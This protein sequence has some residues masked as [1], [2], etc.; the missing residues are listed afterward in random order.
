MNEASYERLVGLLENAGLPQAVSDCVLAAADGPA[1]LAAQLGSDEPPVTHALDPVEPGAPDQAFLQEVAVEGFRGIGPLARLQFEPGPGL[2]LVVG[3]NGSGKSS[4]AEALEML[5]TG[6]TLRWA[7]RTKVWQEGWRNLHHGGPTVVSAKF[8][9]DGEPQPLEISRS[10]SLGA[11]LDDPRPLEVSG[12]QTSWAELGWERPLEQYRPILSYNELGTM[13][14]SR[15]A[16]LYEAL[17][18]VLGLEEFDV[19]LAALRDARLRCERSGKEEKQSRQTLRQRLDASDDERAAPI[20]EQLAKRQ[21]EVQAVLDRAGASADTAAGSLVALASLEIPTAE[22]ITASFMAIDQRSAQVAELKLGDAQRLD[23]L[24]GLLE[25]GLAFHR[26]HAEAER[27]DCPLCGAERR[28]DAAWAERTAVEVAEL[29]QRSQELRTARTAHIAALRA[30]REQLFSPTTATALSE[31]AGSELELDDATSLWQQWLEACGLDDAAFAEAGPDVAAKL[32]DALEQACALAAADRRRR[33]DA[34]RPLHEAI[35]EWAALARRAERDQVNVSTLKAAE[36]WLKD[37]IADLRRERLA[38]VVDGA[39]ANWDELRHE[40]NVTL[41]NVELRKQGNQRYAAFDVAID[42]AD[43]SAF[44]VMSQGELSA[45][46]ISVFLPRAMLPGSPFHFMLIDDPVQSM[47]PAKVDGLARVLARAA[48]KR[49]LIVFTHDERLPEAIRRLAIDARI[50]RVQRRAKSKVEIVA[51]RPPSDR[52]IGEAFSIAKAED[53]PA[54]VKDRVIPG[55][56]RSAI[57]AACASRIRRQLL[58]GGVPHSEIDERLSELTSLTAWLADAFGLPL[59]QGKEI[60]ERVAKLGGG[61]A[62]Q[63]VDIA[64]RGSH[65]DVKFDALELVEGAKRLVRALEE[66]S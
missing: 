58:A 21:P 26:A 38:P 14:S 33:E 6:T 57:E 19:M 55:F 3:R 49:Q 48:A 31:A 60:R 64:R 23:A 62:V 47:D 27:D 56:C 11:A 29:R 13:F 46:A 53:L 63:V 22:A 43:A 36:T 25:T 30:A 44:G 32:R 28:L 10:W 39:K 50:M 35:G 40:S 52:Y 9:I 2:T 8:A 4:F 66:P 20:G 61:G 15:A 17:S 24:A 5:L 51:A 59:A 1:A 42:G 18:A 7:E 41:G 34:W 65:Q 16:A 12:P 37:A 54:G 45:L